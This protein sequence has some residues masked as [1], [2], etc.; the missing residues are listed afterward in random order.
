[1]CALVRMMDEGL[2]PGGLTL[3]RGE[4][5]RRARIDPRPE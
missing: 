5:R 2:K 1:M 3:S 4:E